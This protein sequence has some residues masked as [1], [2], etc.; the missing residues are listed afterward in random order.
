MK[1]NFKSATIGFALGLAVA[2]ASAQAT[3]H[4]TEHE[5]STPPAQQSAPSALH[6]MQGMK[7]MDTM[8][9][10]PAMRQKMMANMAQCRDMMS[11]MME[12]MRHA[13]KTAHKTSGPHE[14]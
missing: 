5:H 3:I 12:H 2:A 9:A 14:H 10:N 4:A 1:S 7:D 13:G 6:D 11:M 8:M